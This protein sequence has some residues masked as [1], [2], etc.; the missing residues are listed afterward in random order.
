MRPVCSLHLYIITLPS[1]PPVPPVEIM[2]ENGEDFE[3]DI[4]EEIMSDEGDVDDKTQHE[5]EEFLLQECEAY[6][7]ASSQPPVA[8]TQVAPS[9]PRSEDSIE[10]YDDQIN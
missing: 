4:Y 5:K 3:Y 1:A 7:I 8:D 9:A 6:S 2:A 10:Q